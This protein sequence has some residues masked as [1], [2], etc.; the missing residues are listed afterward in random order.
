MSDGKYLLNPA[1]VII[2]GLRYCLGVCCKTPDLEYTLLSSPLPGL[3][4]PQRLLAAAITDTE[5]VYN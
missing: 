4:A 1:Q 2:P 5:G 3:P